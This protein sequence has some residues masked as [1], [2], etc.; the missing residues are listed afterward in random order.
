MCSSLNYFVAS[1]RYALAYEEIGVASQNY[2]ITP[3]S[4]YYYVLLDSC[5]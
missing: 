3:E 2:Y 1:C 5:T 4:M